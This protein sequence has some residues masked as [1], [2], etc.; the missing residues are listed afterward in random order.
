MNAYIE[1]IAY[2]EGYH[3]QLWQLYSVDTGIKPEQMVDTQFI[4]LD[5]TGRITISAGYAWDGP[6]WAVDTLNFM[7][8]SLVHDAL[9]QLMRAG[10]LSAKHRKAADSL[11]RKHC[12]EDGM[13]AIRAWWVY[14]GVR[15][16][17]DAAAHA[18][19]ERRVVV[20]PR[21]KTA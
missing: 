17:G 2:R 13:S 7:R 14:A 15:L 21:K 11:L 3:Y 12:I 6:T 20:A 19:S 1:R 18:S 16:G 4:S 9:Y 5:T 8:G 10:L